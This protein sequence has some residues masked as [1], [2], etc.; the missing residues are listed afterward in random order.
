M[1]RFKKNN[2]WITRSSTWSFNNLETRTGKSWV[3]NYLMV[4]FFI[5]FFRKR[6]W[7]SFFFLNVFSCVCCFA[8]FSVSSL[9]TGYTR[10]NELLFLFQKF[11]MAVKVK[12]L[13]SSPFDLGCPDELSISE[14]VHRFTYIYIY[15]V[16][17]IYLIYIY[18]VFK[19]GPSKICGRQPLKK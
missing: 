5:N 10:K 7:T 17:Y 2:K 14:A 9:S 18:K 1:R 15:M 19:N 11:L 8:T 16:L 12:D 13:D 3:R 6:I 4:G